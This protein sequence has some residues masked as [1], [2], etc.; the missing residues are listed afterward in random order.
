MVW[1]FTPIGVNYNYN[2]W[3]QPEEF[4]RQTIDID[5]KLMTDIGVNAIRSFATIPP[6]W[7]T[8]LYEKWGIYTA[9]NYLFGRYGLTVDN[10]WI[11]RTNYSD[12]RTLETLMRKAMK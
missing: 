5:A 1:S 4:I 9:V 10:K 12:Q 8:Y 7:V 6:K 2:L 11:P 3:E